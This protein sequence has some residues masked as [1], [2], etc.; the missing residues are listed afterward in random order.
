[1]KNEWKDITTYSQR[2]TERIPRTWKLTLEEINYEII[3]TRHIY[4][5]DTWLLTCR[6]ANI[7][8]LD[9]KTDD[10]EEAK[11]KALKLIYN[12]LNEFIDKFLKEIR[13]IESR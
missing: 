7:D 12:Y 9:L 10:I 13:N 6:K 8:M 1:M 11:E 5:E 4:Y 3:V 2:D